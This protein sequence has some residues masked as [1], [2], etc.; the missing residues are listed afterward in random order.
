MSEAVPAPP[1][2]RGNAGTSDAPE[3]AVA[4]DMVRRSVVFAVPLLAI[5]ALGWGRSGVVSVLLALGL[6]LVNFVLGASF[7]TWGARIGGAALMGAVLGGYVVRLGIVAAVVLPLRHSWWFEVLPFAA[8]LLV[9]HMGLLVW[10]TRHVSASLAHPGVKPGHEFARR[11]RSGAPGSVSLPST[12][13]PESP[14]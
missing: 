13:L 14:A 5:G 3:R 2:L 10:E 1:V 9:T 6:V 7:I 11:S 12:D 4:F 8:S